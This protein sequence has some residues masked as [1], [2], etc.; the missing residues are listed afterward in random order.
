MRLSSRTSF[1][2]TARNGR[3]G[4]VR[5]PGRLQPETPSGGAG[6]RGADLLRGPPEGAEAE[7]PRVRPDGSADAIALDLDDLGQAG[8]R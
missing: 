7:R 2:G 3:S 4:R 5:C 1:A 6:A 8:E